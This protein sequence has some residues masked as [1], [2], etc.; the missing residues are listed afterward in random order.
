MYCFPLSTSK[1]SGVACESYEMM[2]HFLGRLR[3][4]T[5]NR[6]LRVLPRSDKPKVIAV[7]ILQIGLGFLDLLGVA[8]FGILGALAVT[9]VQSQQPGNRVSAVLEYFNLADYSFQQQTGII[10]VVAASILVIRT[11]LSIL[12]TK[13]IYYFL[14]RRG[15]VISS[16]LISRLLS[17]SLIQVQSRSTQE[18]LYSV[19]AGVG[20]ITLGVLGTAITIVS[21]V[22][23]L[24][25][26]V[27]G[28]FLVDPGIAITTI[29]FFG[30][31]GIVLYFSMNKKAQSLGLE[32][33]QLNIKGNEK[34][35]EVLDS[36]RE[37]V[38]RNRRN[39]Y[40]REIEKYRL[41]LADVL[42]EM[43]FMPNI[44]KYVIESG[45]VIGAVLIAGTQ[46]LLQDARHAV[47]TLAVF[48]AS[49]TRIAPAI[50]RLQQNAISIKSG[51]GSAIPTL[52]LIESLEGVGA[53]SEVS[54][55]LDTQHT[56]FTSE[57]IVNSVSITY[58]GKQKAALNNVSF[59]VKEGES[60]A[61][62]GPSG[63]GKTS[64]VDV[65]LGVLNADSGKITI[66][67]L[68]PLDSISK[69][70][71]SISY[72]PQNVT[73]SNGTIR[74]NVALGFPVEV[75]TDQLIWDALEIAQLS[76][77]VKE[78]PQGL[79]TSVGER[80][81]SISGGQRQRLGIARAMFTKPKLLVLDEATS[82][83]D[84][85]TEADISGAIE[86]LHGHV[87]VILIAHR[88]STVRNAQKVIYMSEGEIRA[89]G[90]FEEVRNA[91]P[92]FDRQA[93]LMGL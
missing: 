22:S 79:E 32:Y 25:I 87:T 51:I 85:Q 33:S 58:P 71:G 29:F 81:A 3:N 53:V 2:N 92:D 66:S 44:S 77:F 12:I 43:Q 6:S 48:L 56:S 78:L 36:Y 91:V 89:A 37:S 70:P 90:T 69:W 45:L 47:A 75:A 88:L 67:G 82:S 1:R 73:V 9:G 35:I 38:V 61:I 8:A 84:G 20:S 74:E 23:L 62:V 41:N 21:D 76:D 26:M 19:T 10:A 60:L 16:N 68:P 72:V 50:M 31:L 57:V 7:V 42:A 15:A 4:S 34:I 59:S 93:Q 11:V 17:Q 49:G 40:A 46:F 18:T 65:L 27:L 63:A 86:S 24:L 64:I 55:A 5:V 14:S 39:Y 30:S 83:L 52:Q 13:R 28:L 54:D 80:G